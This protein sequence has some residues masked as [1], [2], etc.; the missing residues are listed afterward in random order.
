MAAWEGRVRCC[1]GWALAHKGPGLGLVGPGPG[2]GELAPCLGGPG[3]CLG[4]VRDLVWGGSHHNLNGM[5]QTETR[6]KKKLKQ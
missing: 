4:V 2:P 3:A 1:G 5:K 6:R